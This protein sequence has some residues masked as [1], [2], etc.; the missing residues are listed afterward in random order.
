MEKKIIIVGAGIAGLSAGCYAQMNGYKSTIFEMHDIPGGLCTAWKRKGYTFDISMHMLTSSVKGTF[1]QMWKELGVID[2]FKFHYH[3]ETTLVEGMGKKLQFSTDREKLK[4]EMLEISPTEEKLINEFLRIVFGPDMMNAA[5][6]KPERLQNFIDKIKV[7]PHIL[8]LMGT[9]IKYGKVTL[10][11][12]AARFKDPFLKEAIRFF[13]DSPGWPMLKFPMAGLAGFMRAG[14]S[15]AGVP[16]GGSMKVMLHLAKLFENSGGTFK[17]KNQVAELIIEK[18]QV[19]GIRLE[20]GEEHFADEVIWAG[21]GHTLIFELL[22][23]KYI[24]DRIRN[25]YNNWIPVKPMLHV[26]IG[27][28]HDFSELPP[29]LILEMEEPL[30]IAGQEIKWMT[31][32]HHSFDPSMAPA[33]KSAVEVWYATEYDYWEELVKNRKAYDEEKQRIAEFSIQ[34]LDKRWP[35]FANQVEVVDVPTPVTY[36]NYTGNW[37]GSPDGWYLTTDNMREME[38]LHS[39]PGLRN[40]YMAGQWTAPFAGTVISALSGRQAVQLICHSDGKKF[41]TVTS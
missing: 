27:V 7:I 39:L 40:L 41:I 8:P 37:K 12:F 10:Q 30:T 22:K 23:G 34:Q 21:D 6:L 32:M 25:I 26:M 19:K 18:D 24:D 4:K 2:N 5:S 16:L 29:S 3:T 20:T 11:E 17:Y 28:N 1:H 14:I 36:S 13:I 33:G 38:P 35:G 9:F 31:V 15:E